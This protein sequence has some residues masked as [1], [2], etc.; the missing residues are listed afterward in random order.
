M[1]VEL[2][3]GYKVEAELEPDTQEEEEVQL[4]SCFECTAVDMEKELVVVELELAV[5]FG[6]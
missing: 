3:V 6:L 1:L 4:G 2:L 5:V